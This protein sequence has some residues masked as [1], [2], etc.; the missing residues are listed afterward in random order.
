TAATVAVGADAKLGF[1]LADLPPLKPGDQVSVELL[2]VIVPA[3]NNEG[4]DHQVSADAFR[5]FLEGD[6]PEPLSDVKWASLESFEVTGTNLRGWTFQK[7]GGKCIAVPD[8]LSEGYGVSCGDGKAAAAGQVAV[9]FNT[10]KGTGK[11]QIVGALTVPGQA[12]SLS[13]ASSK[14]WSRAASDVYAGS[15]ADGARLV[16]GDRRETLNAPTPNGVIF[17]K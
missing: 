17:R 9:V 15:A 14:S 3:V 7:G 16:L 12:V 10:P 5:A 2:P 4:A 1:A 6:N 13:G 11:P 8:P